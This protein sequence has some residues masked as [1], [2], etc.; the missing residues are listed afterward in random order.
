MPHE[1]G[2]RTL[3]K[4]AGRRKIC[5]LRDN[6]PKVRGG[7]VKLIS[8][9]EGRASDFVA[10]TD[11]LGQL[12]S[13]DRSS[14][15]G[16]GRRRL[17]RKGGHIYRVGEAKRAVYVVLS[18]RLKFYKEAPTGRDVILWFCFPGEVFGMAEVPPVKGRQVNVQSCE[19]SEVLVVADDA[20]YGFL[21]THPRV[22]R[23]CL[24]AMSARMGV[25]SN[26]LVNLI[27]DDTQTRIRRLILQLGA[28]Y[29]TR[30]GQEIQ[31]Q[32]PIT[33]Q[34]IAD[35][36]GANRQTVTKILGELRREGALSINHRRINIESTELLDAAIQESVRAAR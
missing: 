3:I 22:A 16:I 21:E 18:G 11:F 9:A 33:H 14:L 35:M 2:R 15:M 4:A 7:F 20:F 23:L 26:I 5:R 19:D 36:T 10:A 17:V 28:R 27:A 12:S 24:R 13:A 8:S 6:S 25:L 32:I 1:R 31:L 29:G 34:E 30:V